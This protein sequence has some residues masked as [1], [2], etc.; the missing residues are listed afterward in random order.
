MD[1]NDGD[2]R[3][4]SDYLVGHFLEDALSRDENNTIEILWPFEDSVGK[5]KGKPVGALD[6]R[7][8]EAILQVVKRVA[9]E[10]C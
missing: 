6:W 9:D 8:R 10:Q 7:G 5:G 2:Q 4:L 1:D 3:P